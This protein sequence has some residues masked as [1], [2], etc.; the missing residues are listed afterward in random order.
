MMTK[1]PRIL[2]V[3]AF[4]FVLSANNVFA[5]EVV[6]VGNFQLEGKQYSQLWY[7]SNNPVLVGKA[8]AS[9]TVSITVNTQPYTATADT[10]G[11][12]S[13]QINVTS[14]DNN[15]TVADSASTY[16]FILTNGVAPAGGTA[17][18][19]GGTTTTTSTLPDTGMGLPTLLMLAMAAGLMGVSA[20][21]YNTQ[22]A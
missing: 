15:V 5:V 14:G 3:L 2:T 10:A 9:S 4:L 13:K 22:K 6:S 16:S 1:L 7:V 11:N 8:V 12:W 19:S 21:A 18:A 17:S 20:Y